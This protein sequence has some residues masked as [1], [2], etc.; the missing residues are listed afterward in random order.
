MTRSWQFED[1][2]FVVL[3]EQLAKDFLPEPFVFLSKTPL[4]YDYLREKRETAERLSGMRD[5][6]FADVLKFVVNPDI[7]I[8]VN[9]WDG[10]D[11]ERADG[12]IRMLAARK[13]GRGFL[14]TQ[15]PGET[16][17]HG[18]GFTVSECDPLALPDVVVGA[19]PTA[20]AGALGEIPLTAPAA[21]CD[22]IDYDYGRSPVGVVSEERVGALSTRFLRTTP[23][24][25][26]TID[27]IQGES[28]FGPRGISRHRL[29]WRDLPD[30]GRY[31]IGHAAPWKAVSV[32][33]ARL[34]SM[35][36]VRIADVIRVIK[37][38]RR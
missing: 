17:S 30:S 10:R 29:E 4:Y 5:G 11:R 7:R 6:Y 37:A 2:E 1:L 15:L 25:M 23:Q 26:G 27:V 8:V 32:D 12:R 16:H 21:T 19:L 14:I 24:V 38:E 22:E 18:G 20:E 36:N 3:W 31:A 9:G 13:G 35:I 33:S 28:L 34:I